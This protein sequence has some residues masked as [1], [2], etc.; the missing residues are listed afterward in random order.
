MLRNDI[1]LVPVLENI[2][3]DFHDEH[4][5][6]W[7]LH[8]E[9]YDEDAK[10]AHAEDK[11][12]WNFENGITL[13]AGHKTECDYRGEEIHFLGFHPCKEIALLS[14]WLSKVVVAYDLNS[15]KVQYLGKLELDCLGRSFPY[16]PCWTGELP[17]KN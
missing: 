16:T 8:E 12:E 3:G 6:S 11:F 17:G 15:S 1:G 13:E 10:E 7:I 14:L 9:S 5:P 4:S 2:P